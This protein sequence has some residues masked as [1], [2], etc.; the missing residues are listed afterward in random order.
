ME[1]RVPIRD[2]VVDEGLRALCG[3]QRVN[4]LC[5]TMTRGIPNLLP[6]QLSRSLPSRLKFIFLELVLAKCAPH[7]LICKQELPICQGISQ[8]RYPSL[9]LS[10]TVSWPPSLQPDFFF[11]LQKC[12]VQSFNMCTG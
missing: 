10:I 7:A 9:A 4:L 3:Q 8:H 2:L 11:S 12:I 5:I 6:R 1:R